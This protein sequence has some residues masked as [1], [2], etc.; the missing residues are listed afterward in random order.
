LV[1]LFIGGEV[2]IGTVSES[3][4]SMFSVNEFKVFQIFFVIVKKVG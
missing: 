2:A 3:V 4:A 1:A